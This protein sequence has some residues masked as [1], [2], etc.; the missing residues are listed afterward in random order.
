MAN[1]KGCG[2]KRPWHNFEVLSIF[3]GGTEKNYGNLSQDRRDV[4]TSSPNTKQER[5]NNSAATVGVTHIALPLNG[6]Y[7]ECNR[8]EYMESVGMLAHEVKAVVYPRGNPVRAFLNYFS[9]YIHSLHPASQISCCFQEHLN[10][11]V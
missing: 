9:S 4:K 3:P 6:M 1:L 7:A 8:T 10:F 11:S 2:R 5:S